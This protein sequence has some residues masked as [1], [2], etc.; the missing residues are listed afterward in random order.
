MDRVAEAF[1][2][3]PRH[4]FLPDQYKDKSG[5]DVPLPIGQGVTNSQP[6][7]VK[8]MLGWLDVKKGM[9]VLDVG[10]GSGWTSALLSYLVG[11]KGQVY[12]V[13][14]IGELVK[15]GASNCQKLGLQNI[16]FTKAGKVLG[17]A[18]EAPYERILVSAQSSN[19]PKSLTDQL[20]N[21]GR[22][23]IP[24][25]NSIIEVHKDKFGNTAQYE[26]YGYVFVP[27]IEND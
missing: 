25:N 2:H 17:W 26:H 9:K 11:E 1:N 6:T 7:T 8:T 3:V 4:Y 5:L 23:V 20:A 21:G 13:E 18:E 10:S 12:A 14:R 19:I 27:L 22:M 16:V 15:I 24:V